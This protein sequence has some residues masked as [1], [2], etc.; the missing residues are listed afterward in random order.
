[1]IVP[2]A[3][4]D[5][6]SSEK[7][8]GAGASASAAE[9]P[10]G[11]HMAG[12]WKAVNVDAWQ[13]DSTRY[14]GKSEASLRQQFASFERV[15]TEDGKHHWQYGNLYHGVTQFHRIGKT[16][17]FRGSEVW[18]GEDT[19]VNAH[20]EGD[21]LFLMRVMRPTNGGEPGVRLTIHERWTRAGV[22]QS[23]RM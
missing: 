9:A 5:T 15:G 14:G 16:N 6:A 4:R 21:D 11:A 17:R 8:M 1:M 10:A 22:T 23:E 20:L 12:T 13:L 19:L 3:H 2:R 18:C 7:S